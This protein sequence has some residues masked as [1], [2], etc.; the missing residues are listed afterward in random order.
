[1]R[2][3]R[4]SAQALPIVRW[5]NEAGGMTGLFLTFLDRFF[6]LLSAASAERHADDMRWRCQFGRDLG[7]PPP[8]PSIHFPDFTDGD[9][10]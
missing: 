8:H 5:V 9:A 1:M 2:L 7:F 4:M 10:S 6:D 3:G